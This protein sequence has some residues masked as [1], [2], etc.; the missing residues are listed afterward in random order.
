[1]GFIL[2]G[3]FS[4]GTPRAF[5]RQEAPSNPA[6]HQGEKPR[7]NSSEKKPA[8]EDAKS[9]HEDFS[10]LPVEKSS[11]KLELAVLG[12][13]DDKPGLPYIRER[14]HLEWRPGDPIDVYILKPR[15]VEK[16]PVVLYLYSYP[17]D[18]DRFKTDSWG[19]YVTGNGFAA[20]GFV[21]ALTG[22]RWEH[23][24]MNATFFTNLQESLG[25]T[26]HDVQMILNYLSTRKDLD[27]TRVGMFG[28]GSGGAIAIL[29]SATDARIKAVDVLTPWGDWPTFVGTSTF[30]PSED[31]LKINTPDSLAKIA[32]LD[33]IQ[34]LPK[35]KA[36]SLRIQDVR[37]DGHMPDAAQEH[38]EAAAPDT[39]EINQYGDSAALFPAAANGR[40]L[41]WIK[42]QLQPGAKPPA[43]IEKSQRIHYFPPKMPA[44]SPIGEHQ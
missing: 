11:L 23:H 32:P 24:A 28:Q 22:H 21:S 12:E 9:Y 3:L 2:I 8:A 29:T 25:A 33:P 14:W 1:M 19:G 17:Q 7:D 34:W 39:A 38:L 26:V 43:A 40:L 4:F 44:G 5:A 13:V 36:R 6:N 35:V 27:M 16:P 20:V 10:V 37:K 15:G 31:R 42:A 41:E 18:T 30:I